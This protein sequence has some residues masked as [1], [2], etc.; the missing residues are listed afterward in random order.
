MSSMQFAGEL[1]NLHKIQQANCP[2]CGRHA[3]DLLV[4]KQNVMQQMIRFQKVVQAFESDIKMANL[5]QEMQHLNGN[6]HRA[7]QSN[8]RDSQALISQANASA[9]EI[10]EL[11]KKLK[12]ITDEN[13]EFKR[14]FKEIQVP[15]ENKSCQTIGPLHTREIMDAEAVFNSITDHSK[16]PYTKYIRTYEQAREAKIRQSY[17]NGKLFTILT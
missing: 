12:L 7:S 1:E 10:E 8:L 16:A 15:Q 3:Q 14:L 9:A 4:A 2:H 6:D 17:S 11:K 13:I 5:N